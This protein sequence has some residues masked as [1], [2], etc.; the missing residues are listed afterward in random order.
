VLGTKNN[1][2][3]LDFPKASWNL[4][5]SESMTFIYVAVGSPS[6]QS[7]ILFTP[8]SLSSSFGNWRKKP[9]SLCNKSKPEE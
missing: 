1:I 4:P 9:G 3:L 7:T 5:V 8:L 2:S 6:H